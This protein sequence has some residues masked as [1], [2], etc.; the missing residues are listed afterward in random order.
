MAVRTRAIAAV[1]VL[2]IVALLLALTWSS[3]RPD[4]A[5]PGVSRDGYPP[6]GIT[7]DQAPLE[8]DGTTPPPC[9]SASDGFIVARPFVTEKPPLTQ[10]P[11]DP[12]A[13]PAHEA[14]WS[15]RQ[16]CPSI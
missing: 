14:P 9:R 6:V 7:T 8:G 11:P 5:V 12:S 10:Q 2:L 1:V 4:A 15:E 13:P 3:D 16:D